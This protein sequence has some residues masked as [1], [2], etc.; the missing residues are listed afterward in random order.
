MNWEKNAQFIALHNFEYSFGLYSYELGM[1]N[2]GD[3][4]SNL[5]LFNGY[6]SG[7]GNYT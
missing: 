2:L 1:N 5:D 4:V 6:L 7:L 3:M